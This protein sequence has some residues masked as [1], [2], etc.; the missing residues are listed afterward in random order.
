MSRCIL[1]LLVLCCPLPEA[2]AACR[3]LVLGDSLSAAYGIDPREGWVALLEA[4]LRD[5]E[6][7]CELV[8][9]SIPGETSAGGLARLDR[10]LERFSPTIVL[11]ELGANDGLRGLPPG[12]LRANLE[13][14]IRKVRRHG[15]LPVLIGVRLPPNYGPAYREAYSAVYLQVADRMEVPLVPR[16]LE[17]VGERLELMQGDGLHPRAQAQPRILDNV[18]RVLEPLLPPSPRQATAAVPR[19]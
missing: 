15:A 17:G 9:S 3:V 16:L 18:W 11:I 5:R 8:N 14:M 2:I 7:P 4:R 1:L 6:P 13:A 12:R 10:A 19:A